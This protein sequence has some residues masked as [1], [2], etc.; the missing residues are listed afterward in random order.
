A[1]SSRSTRGAT[2]EIGTALRFGGGSVQR[3]PAWAVAPER[4][5]T[6][7]GTKRDMRR[8]LTHMLAR[9]MRPRICAVLTCALA[10]AARAAPIVADDPLAGARTALREG[11]FDDAAK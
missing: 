7:T 10:V 8:V 2:D 9:C 1:G 4:S 6:R 11:R 3:S 5:A